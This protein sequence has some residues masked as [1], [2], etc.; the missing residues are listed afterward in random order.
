[1]GKVNSDADMTTGYEVGPEALYLPI[2]PLEVSSVSGIGKGDMDDED[3]ETKAG[4][5]INYEILA[6]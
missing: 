6:K 4:L 5:G 3:P 1:M 2:D